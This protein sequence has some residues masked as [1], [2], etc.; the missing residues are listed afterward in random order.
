[1]AKPNTNYDRKQNPVMTCKK[2]KADISS[3][4]KKCA[5]KIGWKNILNLRLN[6]KFTFKPFNNNNLLILDL[7]TY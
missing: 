4:R 6:L 7:S 3:K 5:I 2:Y 1:M